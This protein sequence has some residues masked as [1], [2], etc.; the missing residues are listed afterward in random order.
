MYAE[1][2]RG[3]LQPGHGDARSAAQHPG[4]RDPGAGRTGARD[5]E[6]RELRI[7][8][9]PPP[10]T[11][12]AS[13]RRAAADSGGRRR[14]Q[15]QRL[16]AGPSWYVVRERQR[17]FSSP[18][19]RRSRSGRR[20]TRARAASGWSRRPGAAPR[21]PPSSST[22]SSRSGRTAVPGPSPSS[23][24]LVHSRAARA[25]RAARPSAASGAAGAD[26][27]A[28]GA[29]VARA[30]CAGRP[31]S[32]KTAAAGPSSASPRQHQRARLPRR[33]TVFVRAPGSY[34]AR[35]P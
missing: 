16:G 22:G 7:P 30:G 35:N 29:G 20:S 15:R 9:P 13:G 4:H 33:R 24:L 14:G 6:R 25:P 21:S 19:T 10:T 31:G 8:T 3:A 27:S 5:G 32:P 17:P 2:D 34:L 18:G 1:H 26:A 11:S 23:A 12:S 28:H